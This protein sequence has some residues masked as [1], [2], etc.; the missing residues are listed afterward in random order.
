MVGLGSERE[1]AGPEGRPADLT[2]QSLG[3]AMQ[4]ECSLRLALQASP[5]AGD[6]AI[7]GMKIGCFSEG[8]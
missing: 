4:L 2:C 7:E 8:T 5:S 3:M 1:Q 6:D